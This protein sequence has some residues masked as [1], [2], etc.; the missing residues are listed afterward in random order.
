MKSSLWFGEVNYYV[1]SKK[2]YLTGRSQYVVHD[3]VKSDIYNVTFG[4]PQGSILGPLLFIL[5]MNDICNVS[6]LL[7][8][9]LYADDTC[10]LLSGKDLTKLIMVINA[11]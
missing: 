3:G 2:S 4:V 6:E 7:F 5:N 11:N 9:I 10:V 1:T 8:T